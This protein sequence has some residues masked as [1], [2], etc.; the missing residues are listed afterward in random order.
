MEIRSGFA[1]GHTEV[2][3]SRSSGDRDVTLKLDPG[4]TIKD[5]LHQLTSIGP[6][7]EWDDMMLMVFVNAEARGLDNVLQDCDTIYFH[8]PA[9]GG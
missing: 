7:D 3:K 6:S 5:L 4:T 1:V 9:G 8:I 2:F